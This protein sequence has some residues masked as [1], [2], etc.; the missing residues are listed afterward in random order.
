MGARLIVLGVDAA[1]ADLVQRW[2]ADGELPAMAR[3]MESGTRGSVAGVEGFFVGSTW[4]TFYTGLDPAGHGV[5]RLQQLRSGTYELFEPLVEPDGMAGIPFWRRASDAGL[6]VAVL[7]V[8]LSRLDPSLN[9]VQTV[10]WGGHDAVFGFQTAPSSLADDILGTVGPYPLPSD[11]NGDRRTAADFDAFVTA[12]EEAVQRKTALTLDILHRE[13]WDL[14]VQVF[15]EAHCCGHQCWHLHDPRH[16]AHDPA[17]RGAVGDP[18]ERIYR[19]IDRAVAAI[20]EHAGEAN[21]LLFSAHGMSFFRGAA[22]LLPAILRRLGAT[23]PS[24]PTAGVEPAGATVAGVART[25]WHALPAAA[26]ERL[27]PLR[28]ALGS[29][30][31]A[32]VGP[33]RATWVDVRRSRC[34]PVANGFP[35]GAIRLNLRGRE[36]QGVLEP[37]DEVER[38][39]AE[40]TRELLA[41]VD[42]RTDRPL[43]S[44]VMRTD[45]LYRGPRRS[46]LPDLLV[47]WSPTRPTGT[48]AHGQGLGAT[49][50]ASSSAVGELEATNDWVRTGEHVPEGF[51]VLT[52]PDVGPARLSTPVPLVDFHP[53]ICRLLGLPA[54]AGDGA[55]V[56]ALVRWTR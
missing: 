7:D 14:L 17:L 37:G 39:C 54:P 41:I 56:D 25:I 2:T 48:T 46:A 15:T 28:E 31:G 18:L 42:E 27:R 50:R 3:L 34:F 19:A 11:C 23:V 21:V 29:G 10:E 35:V 1:S 55:P 40:L 26:R 8:P 4:P 5:Y 12:L 44:R 16:P 47:E 24:E 13:R 20:V 43:I 30:R 32:G 6:R 45:E 36:P 22:P 53:T 52:G 33:E 49:V 38:F 51:F 9:G